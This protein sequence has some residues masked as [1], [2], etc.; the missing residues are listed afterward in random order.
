M[1]EDVHLWRVKCCEPKSVL[2]EAWPLTYLYLA[3]TKNQ[4]KVNTVNLMI[5]NPCL[6]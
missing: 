2:C 1:H 4:C 6:E 5:V 3:E